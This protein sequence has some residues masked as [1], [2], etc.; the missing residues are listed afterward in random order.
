MSNQN[1]IFEAGSAHFKKVLQSAE[2]EPIEVPEWDATIYRPVAI[3]MLR[4]DK[5]AKA[6]DA[7]GLTH[8][9]DII[10]EVARTEENKAMFLNNKYTRDQF[11]KH[12]DPGVTMRVAG[13]LSDALLPDTDESIDSVTEKNFEATDSLD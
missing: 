6:R 1:S 8:M 2:L 10:I 7:G 13:E 12:F 4:L 11:M 5:I 3:S 9:I